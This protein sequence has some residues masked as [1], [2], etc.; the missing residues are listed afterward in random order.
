M[1]SITSNLS[2][3][4]LVCR[5]EFRLRILHEIG[6][7]LTVADMDGDTT[8]FGMALRNAFSPSTLFRWY[9]ID[10]S[11]S[12]SVLTFSDK[13][14][15]RLLKFGDRPV[16]IAASDAAPLRLMVRPTDIV[17]PSWRKD[18]IPTTFI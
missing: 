11:D 2:H 8:P 7:E 17:K 18:V 5:A 16:Q 14:N 3:N 12:T 9:C 13:P 15:P 1:L 6:S 10:A 4:V